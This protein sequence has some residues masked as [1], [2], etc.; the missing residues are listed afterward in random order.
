VEEAKH[1]ARQCSLSPTTGRLKGLVSGA[2][3]GSVCP[4]NTETPIPTESAVNAKWNG[5]I[6]GPSQ[7]HSSSRILSWNGIAVEAHTAEPGLRNEVSIKG[8]VLELAT[9]YKPVHGERLT[10]RN[11]WVPYRKEP[12]MMYLYPDGRLP[13]IHPFHKTELIVCAF[14]PGFL[15]NA[16][17]EVEAPQRSELIERL[18]FFDDASS[19][20]V[21]LLGI[22]AENGG[23]SGRFYVD[24]LTC[25]LASRLLTLRHAPD[26][27]RESK[28]WLPHHNLRRVIERMDAESG[29]D[30]DLRTLAAES[31][32]SVNHFLKVFRQTT[33][34]TPYQF[35][36]KRRIDRVKSLIGGS[37]IS[38]IDVANTCGFSSHAQLSR[39]F[40]RITG[41]TPSEYRRHSR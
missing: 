37:A 38:L 40:R 24:H 2:P 16:A 12:G 33:G 8:H 14:E 26:R 41:M 5:L 7:K 11:Q 29:I 32:Y 9:G 6:R 35:L 21:R 27:A 17:L 15:E 18:G 10:A 1:S 36:L 23:L 31:G 13:G 30:L 34:C 3:I 4:A 22:E 39:V 28:L 25:A 19:A 20:L